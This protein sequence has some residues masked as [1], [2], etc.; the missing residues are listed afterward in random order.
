MKTLV[1]TA[2]LLLPVSVNAQR[3]TAEQAKSH[4]GENET[5]CGTVASE[6]FAARSKGQPTFINLDAAS[7]SGVYHF[8]MG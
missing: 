4:E 8:D 7:T 2:A 1:L 5:V 3:I 6:H